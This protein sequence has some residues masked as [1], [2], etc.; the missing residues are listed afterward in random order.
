MAGLVSYASSD[1]EEEEEE[2]GISPEVVSTE[3]KAN[4]K[5]SDFKTNAQENDIGQTSLIHHPS[6]EQ[7]TQGLSSELVIGPVPLG[8]SLPSS[9]SLPQEDGTVNLDSTPSSPYSSNRA[10]LHEL[11]LP[12]VPNL[13][14]P[15]SPPGSPPPAINQKFQ[16]F[17]DLKRK[18]THFNSKLELS[19]ALRNPSL[20]DKLLA[21][22]DLSGAA[23][24]ETTLPSDLY[25]PGGFPSWAF[26][27]SLRKSRDA[28][29]KEKG[30]EKPVVR[31]VEFVSSSGTS[32]SS[33]GA[34]PSVEPRA[35]KRAS[36][37]K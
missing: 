3:V 21:F 4:K 20:A 9:E 1:D 29:A 16:Q 32:S 19:T 23:Q 26:R 2:D 8:P 18:G 37:W 31:G 13:D 24:Y 22:V 34:I 10:L 33:G 12:S 35:D 28:L 27:E 14:I 11:T 6:E 30:E 36:G 5:S 15:M 7:A 25:D 17:L